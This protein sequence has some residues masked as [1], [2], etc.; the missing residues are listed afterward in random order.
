MGSHIKG[1]GLSDAALPLLRDL[2]H[3]RSGI[4]F[5]QARCDAQGA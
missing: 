3:E 2:V 5:E 4:F 1:L